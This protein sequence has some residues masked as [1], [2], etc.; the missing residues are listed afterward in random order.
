VFAVPVVPPAGEPTPPPRR[1]LCQGAGRTLPTPRVNA[2]VQFPPFSRWSFFVEASMLFPRFLS[3][4]ILLHHFDVVLHVD[5]LNDSFQNGWIRWFAGLDRL[6]SHSY[7]ADRAR[8]KLLPLL[9][10]PTLHL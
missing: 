1:C 4:V 2:A 5:H 10:R 6:F 9:D 3:A 7:C 8:H